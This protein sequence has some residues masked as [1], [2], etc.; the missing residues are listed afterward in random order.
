MPK[1]IAKLKVFSIIVI[2][3]KE[4]NVK[5]IP[6]IIAINLRLKLKRELFLVI[7]ASLIE[8]TGNTHG[9]KFNNN[10]PR[11]AKKSIY[12]KSL[13]SLS[14][15]FISIS[16]LKFKL[17]ILTNLLFSTFQHVSLQTVYLYFR[18]ISSVKSS[19]FI[20]MLTFLK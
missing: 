16:W 14:T 2:N 1:P 15:R 18:N 6:A 10:P 13:S 5:N 9:M 7:T 3:A 19:I 8:S 12:N 4:M 17:P 11:K 20:G